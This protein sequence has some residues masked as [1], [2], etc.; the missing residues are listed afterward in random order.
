MLV[1][2]VKNYKD[3][4]KD[5]SPKGS[6]KWDDI[7]FTEEDVKECD[8]V[9]VLNTPKKDAKVVCNPENV[10]AIMQEPYHDGHM[11]WMDK[12]LDNY[13]YV[14]TNH[15]PSILPKRAEII[16]S[17]GALH[18]YVQKTYDELKNMT[19]APKKTEI[20][21]CIASS[22]T[23][24]PGHK[25][26]V[27]FI[28][29]VK[30]NNVLNV[31]FFGKGTKFLEDKWD[32]I[33]PYKYSIVIENSEIDDYW[34][35]K[36]SDVYLGFTL[37]FYFGCTNIDKY[38]PKDSYIWIDI[39]DPEQAIKTM[40]EAIQN[41]EWEKRLQSIIE[42]RQLVLDKYNLFPCVSDFIK[43]HYSDG[44]KRKIKIPAYK[45]TMKEKFL[46]YIDRKKS[47]L[48]KIK[49]FMT[50]KSNHQRFL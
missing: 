31:D 7:S 32:G 40:Q 28:D 36:I 30:N 17:H 2:I 49:K 14:L 1:R 38:F 25:K 39:S 24:W 46:R 13:K 45:Y 21:S 34:T 22:L 20:I 47:R 44:E 16:Y 15:K 33:A 41:N 43:N 27:E 48:E 5:Y 8:Y 19:E 18:W 9:V 29:Y 6:M 42:A 37:P 35:E 12:Q 10:V 50:G 26:R 4:Y 23:R 11:E 3:S